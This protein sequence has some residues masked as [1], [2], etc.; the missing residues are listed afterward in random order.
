[1]NLH[2]KLLYFRN[3]LAYALHNCQANIMEYSHLQLIQKFGLKA[4][5]S[6]IYLTY[7]NTLC[8]WDARL[9]LLFGCRW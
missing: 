8:R 7:L 5:D 3:S 6:W 1:M 2:A 4:D 9:F